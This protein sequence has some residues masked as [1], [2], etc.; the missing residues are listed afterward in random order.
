MTQVQHVQVAI[1]G[2]GFAGLGMAIRLRQ[3]GAHDFVVFERAGEVGGT[4]RDNT[5]PGCACDIRSDLYSFSFAPNPDWAHRYARQPEILAYLKRAAEQ[6]GVTPH[7]RFG[8]E[9]QEAR[10]DDEAA[11]WRIQT[12][13]GEYSARVLVSGHGPLIEPKWPEIPGLESFGSDRVRAWRVP[14]GHADGT[15]AAAAWPGGPAAV[16]RPVRRD[17]RPHAGGRLS[18]ARAALGGPY[19]GRNDGVLR[20][21]PA[22]HGWTPLSPVRVIGRPGGVPGHRSRQGWAPIL[23]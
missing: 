8:H 16:P 14:S 5:Y 11:L 4:W 15:S 10:W 1:L 20:P 6:Y 18:G 7:I 21:R 22:Q 2:T 9:V 17:D 23:D 3:R 19:P 12:S 13:R